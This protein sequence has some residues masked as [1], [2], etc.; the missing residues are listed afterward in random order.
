MEP[1]IV[2]SNA[3]LSLTAAD[4]SENTL[5]RPTA[6]RHRASPSSRP[7]SGS[8]SLALSNCSAQPSS[9]ACAR[10]ADARDTISHAITVLSPG[11]SE[12]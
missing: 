7:L 3:Q 11:R 5:R 1:V 12:W 10:N 9:N 6:P 4:Q 2:S 8:T